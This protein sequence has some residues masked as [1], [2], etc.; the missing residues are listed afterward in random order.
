MTKL[1]QSRRYRA[2]HELRLCRDGGVWD[3][4]HSLWRALGIV[5]I[6]GALQGC[7]Y[8]NNGLV[9]DHYREFSA[10]MPVRNK[11]SVCSAYG[12]RTKTDFRLTSVDIDTLKGMMAAS[13]GADTA[14]LE[15]TRIARALAWTEKRVGDVVGTSAD[16]PGDDF[17]GNGDPTQMD[18]VDVATNLTSYLLVLQNNGFLKHHTVG[19]IYAKE[20]LRRG[21]DGWLHYTAIV[22]DNS[23]KRRYAVDGWKLASG[24]EPEIVETEKWYVDDRDIGFK[25]V[26][27]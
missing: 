4:C 8:Q 10:E 23:S 15:R 12:C 27:N 11:I 22:V 3:F 18:C 1:K 21:L 9:E 20:D 16:R 6:A 25:S 17:A 14:E 13:A 5:A 19:T 24:I 7:S 26:R 2:S